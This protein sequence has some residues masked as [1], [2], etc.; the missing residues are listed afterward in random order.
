MFLYSALK[1]IFEYMSSLEIPRSICG[2][3]RVW[4]FTFNSHNSS[5]GNAWSLSHF[6]KERRKKTL[7]NSTTSRCTLFY[8]R[9]K[10][11]RWHAK[12]LGKLSKNLAKMAKIGFFMHF[13]QKL[14]VSSTSWKFNFESLLC[15]FD[16]ENEKTSWKGVTNWVK[17]QNP[18]SCWSTESTSRSSENWQFAF[19]FEFLILDA[20]LE[21]VYI[22]EVNV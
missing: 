3:V 21:F 19:V 5:Q 4:F 8:E 9:N 12:L 22:L 11:I 17:V 10:C 1:W 13:S 15:D 16:K 18:N 2:S 7:N 20:K 14:D 6:C